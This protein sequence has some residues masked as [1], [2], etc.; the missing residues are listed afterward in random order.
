MAIKSIDYMNLV[1]KTGY[2]LFC[3]EDKYYIESSDISAIDI[4]L[5]RNF[6]TPEINYYTDNHNESEHCFL[7]KAE[8][9]N[10]M[11]ELNLKG[12]E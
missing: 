1:G 7:T 12:Q 9:K 6:G 4:R 8:A 11:K 10:K 5:D 2:F 3:N